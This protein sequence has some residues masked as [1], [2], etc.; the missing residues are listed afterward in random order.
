[1]NLTPELYLKF[2]KDVEPEI[3]ENKTPKFH[4]EIIRFIDS[5]GQYKAVAVFRGA[6]KTTLLNKIYVLSRLYFAAEPFIMIVSA[7]EDKATAFLEAI[8]GSIDKAAAKG[9]AIARGKAWN[10]GFIE[11]MI[12]QG[13]KDEAGKSLE[14]KC[15]V[16]S[17]SAGQDP[18]GMNIDNMR[19][20]LL[21]I[22]DLE[23]KVGRYPID[24]NANRQKLR[25]WFYADLLPTL[26]PTRGRAVILGTILHEDSILNNIVNNTEEMDAKQ[27]W[28]YIKIPIIR[29][30]VSSWPSRFSMDKIKKIQ[31]TLVSKGMA[32]EFYQEYM[33]AAIDPQKAIFKREYFRY[34]K[35]VEY[36]ADEPFTTVTV[37]DG[38][39]KQELKIRR[40]S[41]IEL[42][43]GEKIWLK[44]CQIYTVADISSGKGRDQTAYV[45]FAIDRQNRL[46]IIDITSGYFTP[47]ERSLKII[48]IYLTFDPERIGIEKAGMQNDFFYTIDTI[49]K[50]TGVNL[51]IDPL[52]HGGNSKNKRISNLEPYYR[53]RQIYHNANLNATDELEAQ[54]LGFD[55]ET[56]SKSDDIM[57]AAAYILQYIAGRFFDESYDEI[58]DEYAEEESWV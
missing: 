9:Y 15:Y 6:G 21:I 49:Q 14:K 19:P 35:G 10:K 45:T 1:M 50:L 20:T 29:N 52:S 41:K 23:S 18:R 44:E 17:L 11:V 43:N 39:N 51:P 13:I 37:T 38:V 42:E 12:N 8:K 22:D 28:I 40:A 4:P 57:D 25:S 24:S 5:E 36:R 27:E 32:N 46:F 54:L 7:N 47:F 3:F 53:T 58:Y 30:G 34:F 33:C 56:E 2:A 48:E 55:P 16:V 31:S 26:H